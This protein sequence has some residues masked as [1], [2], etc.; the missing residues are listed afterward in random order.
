MDDSD[1]AR[2]RRAVERGVRDAN[3]PSCGGCIFTLLLLLAFLAF[4]QNL[5]STSGR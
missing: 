2:I 5:A 3:G 4:V 1:E